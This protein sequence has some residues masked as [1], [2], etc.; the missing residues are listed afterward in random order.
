MSKPAISE[1]EISIEEIGR[2][3]VSAGSLSV[4]ASVVSIVSGLMSS[5]ILARLLSP[6]EFG[7]VG[8][9]SIHVTFIDTIGTFGLNVQL[10]RMEQIGDR[11]IGTNFWL[12]MVLRL[13]SV[14]ITL[15]LV[16]VF[17]SLYP[18]RPLLPSVILA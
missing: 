11:E 16:P 10:I 6:S 5:V 14:L 13:V 2:Q 8:L 1:P 12:R 17:R 3:S 15:A 18:D 4:V 7:V 9:A